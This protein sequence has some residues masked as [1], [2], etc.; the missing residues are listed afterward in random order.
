MARNVLFVCTGNIDRSPTA[1][2][3]LK[4]KKG[5]DVRSAGTWIGAP[6]RI[7]EDLVDWADIILVMEE[8]HKEA[9]LSMKP[10]A[11]QKITVLEVPNMYLRGDPELVRTLK[12]K[13]SSHLDIEW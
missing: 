3:L 2:A 13:L 11:E 7:S 10:E 9:I 1:E 5:F 4:K 6:T 12:A 8:E